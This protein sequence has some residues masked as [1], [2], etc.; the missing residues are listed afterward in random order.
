MSDLITI[1]AGGGAITIA[2]G[3]LIA[4][5]KYM[6]G[7]R[8][9]ETCDKI[10]QDCAVSRQ[11]YQETVNGRL[12]TIEKHGDA[13]SSAIFG[14][15]GSDGMSQKIARIDEWVMEQKSMKGKKEQ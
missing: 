10:R 13:L 1:G 7:R 15:N 8:K 5:W 9:V 11:Q 4:L 2:L 6:N 3:G 12:V 14:R